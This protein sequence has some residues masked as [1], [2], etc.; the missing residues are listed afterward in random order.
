MLWCVGQDPAVF[1]GVYGCLLVRYLGQISVWVSSREISR[2]H[3]YMHTHICI[4]RE[5]ARV[6]EAPLVQGGANFQIKKRKGKKK[7]EESPFSDIYLFICISIKKPLY[8]KKKPAPIK[9]ELSET[10]ACL[11]R[12]K[13]LLQ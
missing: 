6:R 8:R 10:P 9:S 2:G 3:S 5:S 1:V 7:R 13:S 4:Q 11:C 12:R